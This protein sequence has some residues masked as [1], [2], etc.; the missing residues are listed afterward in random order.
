MDWRKR[1]IYPCE[2]SQRILERMTC[3]SS[4]CWRRA[5]S[6]SGS[7]WDARLRMLLKAVTVSSGSGADTT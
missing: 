4:G 3:A 7:S 6:C 1:L 5:R 2:D